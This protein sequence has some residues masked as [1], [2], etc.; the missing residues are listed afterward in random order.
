M[1]IKKKP[2]PEAI[3]GLFA[4]KDD[5]QGKWEDMYYNRGVCSLKK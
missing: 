3:A 2:Q 4:K 1:T 5:L